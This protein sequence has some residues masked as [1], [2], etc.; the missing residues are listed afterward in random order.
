MYIDATALALTHISTHAHT[1]KSAVSNLYAGGL[2]VKVEAA[3][4]IYQKLRFAHRNA[5]RDVDVA[6][7]VCFV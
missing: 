5:K 3:L 7:A 1:H 6:A 2:C 4:R